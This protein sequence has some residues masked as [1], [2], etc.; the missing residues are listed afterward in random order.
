MYYEIQVY[1][2]KARSQKITERTSLG[3]GKWVDVAVKELKDTGA[4]SMREAFLK[5]C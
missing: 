4:I 2:G 3:E 5:V 1:F